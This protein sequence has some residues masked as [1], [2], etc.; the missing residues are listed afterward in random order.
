MIFD[1]K[2]NVSIFERAGVT[3]PPPPTQWFIL[4]NDPVISQNPGFGL[5]SYTSR[6]P[7]DL[8]PSSFVVPMS[9]TKPPEMGFVG[10]REVS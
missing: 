3:V 2:I 8:S 9:T 10:H 5:R 4:K 7:T 6:G 1:E